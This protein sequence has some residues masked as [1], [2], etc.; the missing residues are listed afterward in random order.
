MSTLPPEAADLDAVAVQ[1]ARDINDRLI[2]AAED[3]VCDVDVAEGVL[4]TLDRMIARLAAAQAA[5]PVEV[6]R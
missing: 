4:V 6:T 2:A 1:F 3:G 5:R